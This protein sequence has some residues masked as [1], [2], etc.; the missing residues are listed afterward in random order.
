MDRRKVIA[1]GCVTGAGFSHTPDRVA[2]GDT[3]DIA[4]DSYHRYREDVGMRQQP[5]VN[6]PMATPSASGCTMSTSQRAGLKL[7]WKMVA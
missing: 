4:Y 3:G 2:N 6:G 1:S 7:K 5:G